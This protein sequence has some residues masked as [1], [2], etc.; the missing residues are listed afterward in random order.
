MTMRLLTATVGICLLLPGCGSASSEARSPR[1][2]AC[3]IAREVFRL[4]YDLSSPDVACEQ[5]RVEMV[6][7]FSR[8][9]QGTAVQDNAGELCSRAC[10]ARKDGV[11]WLTVS[12][13]LDCN[14][15]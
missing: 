4:C 6:N 12:Q 11:G 14:K 2:Q 13:R 5:I 8:A 15:M 7:T 9:G 1:M 10:D 3:E